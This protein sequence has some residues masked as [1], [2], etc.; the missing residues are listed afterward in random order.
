MSHIIHA[1]TKTID[2]KPVTIRVGFD[3]GALLDYQVV[4]AAIVFGPLSVI[5]PLLI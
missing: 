2:N 5:L 4:E 1:E 3:T